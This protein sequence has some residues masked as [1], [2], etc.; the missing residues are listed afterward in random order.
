MSGPEDNPA[1]EDPHHECRH[2]IDRLSAENQ[3][4]R[5]A[6]VNITHVGPLGVDTYPACYRKIQDYARAALEDKP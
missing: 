1:D 4:L 5:E 6:L 2:E 3:L